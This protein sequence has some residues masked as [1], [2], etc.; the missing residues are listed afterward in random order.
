MSSVSSVA[1]PDDLRSLTPEWV[2]AA[3][4]QRGH[5]PNARVVDLKLENVG[6]GRM[7]AIARLLLTFEGDPGG[8]PASLIAKLPTDVNENRIFGEISGM[9]WREILFYEELRA[10]VP[11]RTPQLYY[12]AMSVKVPPGDRMR[13]VARLADWFPQRVLERF[14]A[15]R[16]R[17]A[18]VQRPRYMLLMEDMMPARAGDLRSDGTLKTCDHVLRSIA[19]LHATFW[20]SPRLA[21]VRWLNGLAI[22]PR[23]R[24]R[25]YLGARDKF[26]QHHQGHLTP[27]DLAVLEWID[28]NGPSLSRIFDRDAP[29]TVIHCDLR[30]DNILFD[31]TLNEPVAF[32]DWQLAA[33]GPAAFDVAYFLSAALD[34]SVSREEELALLHGYHQTLLSNGVAGYPFELL[35]RD[36]QRGLVAVVQVLCS[37]YSLDLGVGLEMDGFDRWVERA[38][39]R[40]RGTPLVDLLSPSLRPPPLAHGTQRTHG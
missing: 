20:K 11:L 27:E 38:F 33:I 24:H 4:R 15:L 32:I 10:E 5:L 26:V 29:E 25:M 1:I 7:G 37:S 3:L 30:F 21:E 19:A 40:L 6:C 14:L 23:M 8:V 16:K 12:S 13:R 2:T 31:R 17:Q 36:Y 18:V 28:R 9:Y 34:P 35:V 39:G 22:N